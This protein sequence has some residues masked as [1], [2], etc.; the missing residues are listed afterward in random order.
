[1]HKLGTYGEGESKGIELVSNFL[2]AYSAI[3][4]KSWSMQIMLLDRNSI[5]ELQYRVIKK[6]VKNNWKT[7]IF[8]KSKNIVDVS[9][10]K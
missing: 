6:W 1:M 8:N 4:T 5:T 9:C 10:L 3:Q 2:M 7:N